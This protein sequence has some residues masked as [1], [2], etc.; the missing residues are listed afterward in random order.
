MGKQRAHWSLADAYV[1]MDGLRLVHTSR[2][3]G[4]CARVRGPW[5]RLVWTGY[6]WTRVVL[7]R[8]IVVQCFFST[9]P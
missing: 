9:Q 2:V 3:H 4:P 5:T 8:S 1:T 7:R 6:P